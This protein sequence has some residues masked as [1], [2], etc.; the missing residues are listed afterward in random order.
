MISD[1]I[2]QL[3]DGDP[4]VRSFAAYYLKNIG[5]QT[6][7]DPL[8]K[9]LKDENPMVRHSAVHSVSLLGYRFGEKKVVAHVAESLNDTDEGVRK[10]AAMVLGTWLVNLIESQYRGRGAHRI[11]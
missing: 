7:I 2:S 1:L 5:D 8:L 6:A 4:E 10:E 11:A 9:R 3:D